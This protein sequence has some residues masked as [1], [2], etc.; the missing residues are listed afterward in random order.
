VTIPERV[1]SVRGLS[2]ASS[3][4]FLALLLAFSARPVSAST[5]QKPCGVISGTVWS[6]D[7]RELPGIKVKIRSA[8]DKKAHWEMYSNQHGEFW[9]AVPVC[10][11]DYLV[12]AD[13]KGY[14]LPDGKKLQAGPDVTVHVEVREHAQ[15]GLHLNYQELT[16]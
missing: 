16:K 12:T 5:K 9:Q 11:V 8:Q 7:N 14:K 15:T 6:P 3:A 13:T 2:F 10:G 1:R 4:A